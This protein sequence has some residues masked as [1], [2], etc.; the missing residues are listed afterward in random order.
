[1]EDAIETSV[2]RI[3]HVLFHKVTDG[4]FPGAQISPRTGPEVIQ[5]ID[6]V[7]FPDQ[8]LDKMG[9]DKT[10]PSRDEEGPQLTF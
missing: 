5:H 8:P 1:M 9:T 6:F 3:R 10:G 4:S 7:P 2:D